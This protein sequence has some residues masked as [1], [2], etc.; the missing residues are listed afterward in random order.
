MMYIGVT[1]DLQRRVLEHKEGRGSKFTT[2]YN[3]CNLV[4]FEQTTE[5]YSAL[6]REK[7]L[8]GWRRQKKTELVRISNPNM[9]DLYAELFS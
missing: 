4:Y 9:R 3:I 7:E 2:K 5:V 1:G 6:E 8:K